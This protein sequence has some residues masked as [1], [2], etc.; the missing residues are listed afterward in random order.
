MKKLKRKSLI[1]LFIT[2][3]MILNIVPFGLISEVHADGPTKIDKIEITNFDVELTDALT[4]Y[5]ASGLI[6]SSYTYPENSPCSKGNNNTYISQNNSYVDE[7]KLVAGLETFVNIEVYAKEYGMN[8]E[9]PTYDFDKDNMDKIEVWI[10]GEKRTDVEVGNYN[11]S[12]R[13]VHLSIPVTV[14]EYTGI[15]HTVTFDSNGGSAIPSQQIADN[16]SAVQPEKPTFEGKVFTG[17]YID[18]ELTTLFQ[19]YNTKITEDTTLYAGW[20][21]AVETKAITKIEINNFNYT[22]T[23]DYTGNEAKSLIGE[24]TYPEDS[25]C[26][27]G[28]NNIW[29]TQEEHGVYG[30]KLV[31]GLETYVELEVYAKQFGMNIENPDNDF[32]KNN[33][34]K[35]EVW[36]NGEKRTDIKVGNYNDSW[37][38][39]HVSI[40]V[41]V[42]SAT[43]SH[44]VTFDPD[45]GTM[46]SPTTQYVADGEFA[47]LPERPTKEKYFFYTW[48]KGG[49]DATLSA[50]PITEDTTF[51][52]VWTKRCIVSGDGNGKVYVSSAKT[53]EPT[54]YYTSFTTFIRD[55]LTRYLWAKPENGFVFKKWIN[56]E[57][58]SIFSTSNPVAVTTGDKSE[59][60][61][62]AIFEHVHTTKEVITTKVTKATL[63]KDGQIKKTIENKCTSCGEVISKKDETTLIYYPKTISLSK[64]EFTYNKKVQ[65]PTITVKDSKGKELKNGTD[66]AVTYSNN[67]SKKIGEYKVTITFKGNY[68]GTKTLTYKINPKGTKLRKLT[69]GSKQFKATWKA[70]KTE[71]TGY[72]LQYA[73]NKNFTSGKKKVNIKK[74]KTTS[75]TVKKL[76]AKKKYYVRIRTYKIVSGKKFY[77]GW[78]KVLNVKI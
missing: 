3:I 7:N 64:K 19:F 46:K 69:K 9:N 21:D 36:I 68:E 71:T 67:S 40:P 48:S 4:G 49:E 37:R 34:D 55:G 47:V 8:V 44:V 78:S 17:W 27:K 31:A 59:I 51:S 23:D 14:T 38:M 16:T 39:V 28:N 70:Q 15:M 24:Y 32:D 33:L 5:E 11:D 50:T 57:D 10:N 29:I 2:L 76:K 62:R 60:K 75:S 73:T 26:S 42:I 41:T 61:I 13:M 25:A 74:N 63:S 43:N 66:Y 18:S 53:E 58:D 65:K 35:I 54:N 77:S 1:G 45:G 6:S 30:E 56:V 72:E 12:W 22:L 52:A 20:R